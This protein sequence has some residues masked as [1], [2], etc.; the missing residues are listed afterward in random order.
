MLVERVGRCPM[1]EPIVAPI[2]FLLIMLGIAVWAVTRAVR[3]RVR[4]TD[5][6][7]TPAE[8]ER[9]SRRDRRAS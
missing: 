1:F 7:G 6:A 9:D 3:R 5:A 4:D 8:A 2:A